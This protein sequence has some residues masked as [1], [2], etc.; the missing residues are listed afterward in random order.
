MQNELQTERTLKTSIRKIIVKMIFSVRYLY[1]TNLFNGNIE[2]KGSKILLR[3]LRH[4]R[5]FLVKFEG[6]IEKDRWI[7]LTSLL[8]LSSCIKKEARAP[9]ECA[10]VSWYPLFR[11]HISRMRVSIR[12]PLS[13]IDRIND[14][15]QLPHNRSD[16]RKQFLIAENSNYRF[17]F[18]EDVW[19]HQLACINAAH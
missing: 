11:L 8:R 9:Q 19:Y 13:F 4:P 6:H 17:L 2:E 12:F 1:N 16:A 7:L 3:Q 15:W 18:Q 5:I 10:Q 14:S